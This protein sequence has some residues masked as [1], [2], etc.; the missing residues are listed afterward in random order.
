MTDTVKKLYR[1]TAKP[2][3][4]GVC[5][6]LGVYLGVD[7]TLVRVLA[8]LAAFASLGTA[9]LVYLALWLLI[10]VEPAAIAPQE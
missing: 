9:G 6:G 2:M 8:V 10:P 7:P 4:G 1:S 5:A 3:L